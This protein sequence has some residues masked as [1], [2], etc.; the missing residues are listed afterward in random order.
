MQ[1]NNKPTNPTN[2]NQSINNHKATKPSTP[3]RNQPKVLPQTIKNKPATQS[4]QT[5][6][7]A[8][9]ANQKPTRHLSKIQKP[10]KALNNQNP[11]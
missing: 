5:I 2:P 10:T 9:T 11:N 7:T 6:S 1:S 8:S 3:T 4:Q